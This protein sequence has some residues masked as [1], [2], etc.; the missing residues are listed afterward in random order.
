MSADSPPTRLLGLFPIRVVA[1]CPVCKT[2]VGFVVRT[3]RPREGRLESEVGHS[4]SVWFQASS[5]PGCSE[6]GLCQGREGAVS[7]GRDVTPL[8]FPERNSAGPLFR[9]LLLPSL[10]VSCFGGSFL[11]R[12]RRA[13]FN[14]LSL[15]VDMR[16]ADV[17]FR[18]PPLVRRLPSSTSPELTFT[19]SSLVVSISFYPLFLF[20]LSVFAGLKEQQSVRLSF[21]LNPPPPVEPDPLVLALTHPNGLSAPDAPSEAEPSHPRRGRSQLQRCPS[22]LRRRSWIQGRDQ[23]KFP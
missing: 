22:V 15:Q 19:F 12:A 1:R 13:D 4:Q 11:A 17:S 20:P 14:L 8:C 9:L 3:D 7:R 5:S 2:V 23:S 18:L 21:P 6:T 10:E 16:Q